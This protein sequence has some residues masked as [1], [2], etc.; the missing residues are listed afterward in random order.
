[1]A[2]NLKKLYKEK[3]V[4][5]NGEKIPIRAYRP[6]DAPIVADMYE[7]Q[8]DL[9]A[10]EKEIHEKG[11]N[12]ESKEAVPYLKKLSRLRVESQ[13]L[14]MILAARGVMRAVDKEAHGMQAEELDGFIAEK[15][16]EIDPESS[17]EVAWVMINLGSPNVDGGSKKKPK[18]KGSRQKSS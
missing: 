10:L 15:G 2:V 12:E 7:K 3:I 13:D 6:G 14:A 16:L 11:E 18:K 1:M 5:V 8:F 9:M 4:E 17:L